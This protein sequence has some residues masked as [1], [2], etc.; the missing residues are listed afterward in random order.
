MNNKQLIRLSNISQLLPIF[1]IIA[2]INILIDKASAQS[3][4]I[5]TISVPTPTISVPTPT[6]SVLTPTISVPTPTI[7]VPTPTISVPTPTISV[8]T[9]TISVPTPTISVPTPPISAT[10]T[11]FVVRGNSNNTQPSYLSVINNNGTPSFNTGNGSAN[12]PIPVAQDNNTV[13]TIN[14]VFPSTGQATNVNITNST[15]SNSY[16]TGVSFTP[17]TLD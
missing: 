3:I 17:P 14:V 6:I 15:T 11:N 2:G 1:L 16:S 9:P 5:P 10:I 12:I 13:S 8:P 7:S 4:T